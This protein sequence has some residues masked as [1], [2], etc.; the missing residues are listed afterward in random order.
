M[1]LRKSHIWLCIPAGVMA[2]TTT[3]IIMWFMP[4][5]KDLLSGL[6]GWA[7]GI[8]P[9]VYVLARAIEFCVLCAIITYCRLPWAIGVCVLAVM[10]DSVSTWGWIR[11]QGRNAFNRG[12][13]EVS[14]RRKTESTVEVSLI[15]VGYEV[16]RLDFSSFRWVFD[17]DHPE[18]KA[19]NDALN[20]AFRDVLYER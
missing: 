17:F 6:Y 3:L 11:T 19:K 10:N 16:R 5:E 18:A 12:K 15:F 9:G 13:C 4:G 1:R 2:T 14:V 8:H 20:R 7:F